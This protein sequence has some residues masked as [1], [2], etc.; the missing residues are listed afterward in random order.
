MGQA[1]ALAEQAAAAGEVPVGAL[2]V[3]HG[4]VV[5]QGANRPRGSHDPTAHAE[6]IALR[7]AGLTLGA[8]RLPGTTLYVTLEPC[9]MCLGAM[10]HAR[11][12]RL[13]YGADDPKTGACGGAMRLHEHPSHNHDLSITGGVEAARCGSLLRAFFQSK[14]G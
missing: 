3:K 6:I 11:I 1:I 5:A 7:A 9:P 12:G 13:V 8:Y 14:R 2:L 10:I 4:E